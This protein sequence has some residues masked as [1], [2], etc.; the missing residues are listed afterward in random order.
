MDHLLRDSSPLEL[1][2]WLDAD[3]E[4]PGW[5]ILVGNPFADAVGEDRLAS[6]QNYFAEYH[7]EYFRQRLYQHFPSRLHAVLLF[8]TRVDAETFR[9]KHPARVF[10]KTLT[11]ARSKGTYVCSFHDASWLDYLRLPHNLSLATLDEIANHYWQGALV[12]EI[13]LTFLNERWREAPVIEALFQ[14]TLEA[15]STPPQ[16]GWLPGFA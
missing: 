1:Y 9:S 15:V 7:L 8:A 3:A 11:P 16:S 6:V 5:D 14:G 10:G 4:L 13:G 2:A 12:E